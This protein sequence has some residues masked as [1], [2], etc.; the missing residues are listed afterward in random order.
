MI[1]HITGSVADIAEKQVVVDV[2]GVGYLVYINKTPE[3]FTLDAT[4]TFHT[5]HAIR[6]NAQELYGFTTRDE[7][8][9]FEL[10]LRI[11]KIGPKSAMQ[12]LSQSDIHT[13][14]KAVLSNDP[15]YLTKMSG[16]GKKTAEKV[17]NELQESFSNFSGAYTEN[18]SDTQAAPPFAADAIDALIALGYPQSDA[19]TAIQNLPPEISTA[20]EAVRAALKQL[21]SS[22]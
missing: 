12:I 18:E 7:L 17:V 13:I 21:G 3:H 5:Y 9:L 14:K 10:L 11:P 8:E 16:I 2:N 4:V 6:E 20:N 22:Q 19:R 1:R 15:V